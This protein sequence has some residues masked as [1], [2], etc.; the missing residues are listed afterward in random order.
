MLLNVLRNILKSAIPTRTEQLTV[1]LSELSTVWLKYNQNFQP[2]KSVELTFTETGQD[3]ALRPSVPSKIQHIDNTHILQGP[4]IKSTDFCNDIIEPHKG[5]LTQQDVLEGIYKI[6]ELLDE[7]GGC[8]SIVTTSINKDSETDEI[9]SIRDTL[10][11]VSLK[12]HSYRVTK[13][14]LKLLK[15]TYREKDY[16]NLIPKMIVT[17]LGHDLGKIPALRESGLYAKADHPLIS[18]QKVNEIFMGKDI[19]WLNSAVDA[20]KNHHRQTNDPFTLL[21][22]EADGKAR[23]IEVSECSKDISIKEWDGWFNV[24]SF[25]EILK[26]QINVIQTGKKWKAFSFGGTVYCQPDFLYEAARKL[27]SEKKVIDMKLLRVSDKEQAIKKV[28][29]SLRQARALSSD[30]GESFWG[31]TYEIHSERFKKKMFLIPIKIEAFGIPH[32]I[33]RRKEGY[34]EIVRSVIPAKKY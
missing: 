21:L 10:L 11:K 18:A 1:T 28:V 8:P 12:D 19:I 3:Q 17:A 13:I 23:E 4:K 14:A 6:I 25:L 15:E 26:P 31:R 30:I 24:R 2:Q 34:L 27:A 33:E 16:E 7:H 29:E 20:I 9:Y 32:E 5:L 22:K